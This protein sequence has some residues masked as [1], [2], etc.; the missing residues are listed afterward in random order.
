MKYTTL[1]F[2]ILFCAIASMSAQESILVKG[3]ITDQTGKPL[4]TQIIFTEKGGKVLK[5]N[6]N[7][8][9]EYSNPIRAGYY[10]VFIKGYIL[11]KEAQYVTIPKESAAYTIPHNIKAQELLPNLIIEQAQVFIPGKAELTPE[12][13]ALIDHAIELIQK[14]RTTLEFEV[15]TNDSYYS[16]KQKKKA[17][18]LLLERVQVIEKKLSDGKV[19]SL[20]YEI[21]SNTTRA[22]SKK[23]TSKT[24]C[25]IMVIPQK[26]IISNTVSGT[27]TD[28][29]GKPIATEIIFLSDKDKEY[30]VTSDSKGNY[31]IKL[32]NDNNYN[33]FVMGYYPDLENT[34]LLL[35]LTPTPEKIQQ[36]YAVTKFTKGA[37][38]GDIA[39]FTKGKSTVNKE[40]S[41]YLNYFVLLNNY[42]KKK[43]AIVIN[44]ADCYYSKNR[45]ANLSKKLKAREKAFIKFIADN[46]LPKD[47]FV[48]STETT[49]NT[50]KKDV[51]ATNAKILCE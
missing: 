38:I 6:S 43:I 44:S 29:A 12:G 13:T 22:T 19:R 39:L 36:S 18:K 49:S 27:I 28:Q 47:I 14:H 8:K 46:K 48:I 37:E 10:S 15:F 40:I 34:R 16:K 3:I 24:N 50:K 35:P 7:N 31:E 5:V 41:E 33:V 1:I 51:K 9:G 20:L 42:D 21:K 4:E 30:K 25:K 17:E 11:G 45:K 26:K 32:P 2:A 23:K